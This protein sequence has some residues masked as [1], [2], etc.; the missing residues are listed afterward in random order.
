M[1]SPQLTRLRSS[2]VCP[3]CQTLCDGDDDCKANSLCFIITISALA[4][5]CLQMST[6]YGIF[7]LEI[8][9]VVPS[10]ITCL[11]FTLRVLDLRRTSPC[12]SRVVNVTKDIWELADKELARTIF[13]SPGK[14]TLEKDILWNYTEIK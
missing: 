11:A 12:A 3:L 1:N 6:V 7:E 13:L 8:A 5:I 14:S 2:S 10:T 4:H 9:D